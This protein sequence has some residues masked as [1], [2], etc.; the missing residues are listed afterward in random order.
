MRYARIYLKA[1]SVNFTHA[2]MEVSSCYIDSLTECHAIIH[3]LSDSQ[4]V[5]S[6]SLQHI[7]RSI[8]DSEINI[9]QIPSIRLSKI[10]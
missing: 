6:R 5:T 8:L 2:S 9:H 3:I 1:V 4:Y 10:Y 7:E